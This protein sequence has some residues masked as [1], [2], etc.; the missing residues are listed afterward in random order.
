MNAWQG[1]PKIAQYRFA[2]CKFH[3]FSPGIE[4]ETPWW[5]AGG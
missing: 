5:E 2:H 3:M 1:K 4:P